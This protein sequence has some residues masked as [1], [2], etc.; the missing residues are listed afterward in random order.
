MSHS[1]GFA[2]VAEEVKAGG[3]LLAPEVRGM[4]D[5][6]AE[7]TTAKDL[8]EC[9]AQ[10]NAVAAYLASRYECPVSEVNAA[11]TLKA[12]AEHRLGQVL[13]ATVQQGGHNKKQTDTVSVCLPEEITFKQSSRAQQL[14]ALP[15]ADIE[16][17][18]NAATVA[19]EKARLSVIVTALQRKRREEAAR[20]KKDRGR[21]V[22]QGD[23]R[24][25]SSALE[26]GS[27]S[28]IFTD[29]PYDRKSVPLYGELA[30]IARRILAPGASLLCYCGQYLLPDILPLMA[31]H[32][33]YHWCCA[34]IHTGGLARMR[35]YGVAVGY[36]PLLWFTNGPRS[37]ADKNLFVSDCITSG[38]REKTD[39][40][41][42]QS[43]VEARYYVDALT[44]A[45]EL[46]FDPFTG[47]GTTLVAALSLGRR[48]WGVEKE[49]AKAAL[50]NGKA[51][52]AYR[53]AHG[54][55][56]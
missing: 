40:D 14:A 28:L 50:A 18:I 21:F 48:A 34:V 23:F 16:A 29:P 31:A 24:Q 42:Q 15:W 13:A 20:H 26:G 33:R 30:R 47:S 4:M 44:V 22:Q 2:L 56:A 53:A 43:Q 5:F 17:G 46:V 52:D 8:R 39:H 25:A 6:L 9:K 19:D 41:W 54:R 49:L 1:N 37:I 55:D 45:N 38:G 3:R 35:E 12:F 27:V 7:T 10:A 36:K 32:L 11:V 51:S